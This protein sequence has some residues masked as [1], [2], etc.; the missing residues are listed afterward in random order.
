MRAP[1]RVC[2]LC[3]PHLP[4]WR[5]APRQQRA[6]LRSPP[7]HWIMYSKSMWFDMDHANA[8]LGSSPRSS[9]GEMFRAELRLVCEPSPMM[10]G[11]MK[12]NHTIAGRL[13]L[14]K[15]ATRF[16]PR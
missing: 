4:R 10:A 11:P 1:D 8:A 16:V 5:S 6:L 3:P 13:A 7:Y 2:V 9:S 14:L 12:R 15:R